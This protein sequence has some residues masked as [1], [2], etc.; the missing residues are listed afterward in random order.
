MRDLSVIQIA[1]WTRRTLRDWGVAATGSILYSLSYL[2]DLTY[3]FAVIIGFPICVFKLDRGAKPE[4]VFGSYTGLLAVAGWGTLP[5]AMQLA[6][7]TSSAI[8]NSM[9]ISG[10]SVAVLEVFVPAAKRLQFTQAILVL[11]ELVSD[12]P[13]T[14]VTCPTRSLDGRWCVSVPAVGTRQKCT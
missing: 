7:M 10:L 12:Q 5:F 1:N 4:E 3:A 14:A 13:L 8:V 6:A 11:S 2:A 9:L